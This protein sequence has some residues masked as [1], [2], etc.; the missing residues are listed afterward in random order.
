MKRER[1]YWDLE[2]SALPEDQ[3]LIPD[4][5]PAKNLRDPEKIKA[6]VADKRAAW[7]EIC[8]LRATTGKIIAFSCAW[9]DD[10][11]QFHTSENERQLLDLLCQDLKDAI[12]HG[13]KAYAFNGSGFDLPFTMQR[14][15]IHGI[16]MFKYFMANYRGRWS[17]HEWF[18]DPMQIWAGPYNRSD[19]ASLKN[20][21]Y[22]LGLGLK[23]GSGKDFS[24][25][26]KS[27]PE[28]AK[29]YSILDVELLRGVVK[30]MAI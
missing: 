23:E 26:L 8:A 5:E 27:D 19:G 29:R 16:P 25:L 15:A 17:L 30:K 7:L 28:A 2:T 14:L 20:V 21:A 22:A 9:D 13:C 10:E 6:D 1:Y 24:T 18:I 11:P 3:L 4:F 12:T